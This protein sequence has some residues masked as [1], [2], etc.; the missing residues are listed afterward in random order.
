MRASLRYDSHCTRVA[1][2]V[3]EAYVVKR[4]SNCSLGSVIPRALPAD[5]DFGKL[6]H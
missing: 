5:G 3:E 4:K 2:V 6:L 1:T